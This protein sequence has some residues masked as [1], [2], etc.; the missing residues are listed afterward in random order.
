M[1]GTD[2]M[3][4]FYDEVNAGNLGIIDEL[5]AESFV[6]HDPIALERGREGVR[7]FFSV[8]YAA[9]PDAHMEVL[10]VVAAGD[11]A[12]AHG[13]FEGTHEGEFMGIAPTGRRISVPFADIVRFRDGLVVEHWSVIDTG[14]LMQQLGDGTESPA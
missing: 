4:R 2:L 7:Q 5:F 13:R 8:A 3:R 11:L 12:M 9:F 1:T 6:E 14:L 10:H